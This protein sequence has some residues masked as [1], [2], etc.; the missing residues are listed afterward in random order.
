MRINAKM[1]KQV[2]ESVA[3]CRKVIT[4]A[5]IELLKKIAK[6]GQDVFFDRTLI[7]YQTK[8]NVSETIL[9]NNIAYADGR[10][11]RE[12]YIVSMGDDN[13]FCKSDVML[14]LSNL[15]AIYD[16][17]RALVRNY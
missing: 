11:G 6:P 13:R 7:L 3:D 10:G 5:T 12:F 9:F 1:N 4:E 15:M 2:N 8:A 14:S 16:E 17:V